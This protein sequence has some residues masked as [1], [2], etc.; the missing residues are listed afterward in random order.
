MT[1]A[2]CFT[3]GKHLCA[4]LFGYTCYFNSS[5]LLLFPGRE[6]KLLTVASFQ[7][8]PSAQKIVTEQ[9]HKKQR[10][11]NSSLWPLDLLPPSLAHPVLKGRK[12]R[13]CCTRGKL[14]RLTER[15]YRQGNILDTRKAYQMLHCHAQ[16]SSSENRG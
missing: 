3:I 6:D 14:G 2:F 15:K 13:T 8:Q 9:K 16:R 4:P 7:R 5:D 12:E 1:E 11:K 10:H